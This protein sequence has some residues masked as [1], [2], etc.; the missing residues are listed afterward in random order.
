MLLRTGRKLRP[1]HVRDFIARQ[2]EH[3]VVGESPGVSFHLLVQALRSDAIELRKVDID[4][5]LLPADQADAFG[6]ERA[7][8]PGQ[9][10]RHRARRSGIAVI[11]RRSSR[12][13]DSLLRRPPRFQVLQQ[14]RFEGDRGL[15]L[16]GLAWRGRRLTEL[17]VDSFHTVT[18][19]GRKL[20]A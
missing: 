11:G 5:D 14:Q 8:Y 7:I 2:S 15:A 10:G 12:S 3:E 4:D 16:C 20:K 13:G 18:L 6:D 9:S 1:V 19:T 17:A